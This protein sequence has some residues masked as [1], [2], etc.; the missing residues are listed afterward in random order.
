[1]CILG[2][3]VQKNVKLNKILSV[4]MGIDRTTYG[5]QKEIMTHFLSESF[6]NK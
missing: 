5:T 3:Q 2:I 4:I 1:M 6:S